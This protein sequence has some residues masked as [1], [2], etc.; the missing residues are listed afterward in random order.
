[1]TALARVSEA[2]NG[3]FTL[4]DVGEFDR[5]MD[6][7]GWVIFENVISKDLIG[8]MIEGIHKAYDT[9]RAIQVKNGI[10]ADTEFTVH[11]LIGQ[12]DSFLEYLSVPHIKPYVAR[13][14]AGKYILNSFGGAINS[15]YS[16]SYA[17][18]IHRDIRSYSGD[19]PLVLNTLVMFDD[20]TCD[21]GSTY[22]MPGGHRLAHKPSDQEFYSV[23]QRALGSAGSILMF[24]SN[25]WH[26]GGDNNTDKPRRSVTPMFCK[27][28]VKPGFDYPRALGYDKADSFSPELRQILGYNARIPATLDEWYQP[29]EKRMYKPDQG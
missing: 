17:H 23:A 20:F 4:M 14:F 19:L 27:P 8:R 21:N 24:N 6:E 10:A 26:A 7:R 25:L 3:E 11:H 1:M 9:C 18:R 29:P 13:Y 22:L 16:R 12:H 28:F 15:A 5:L 2:A